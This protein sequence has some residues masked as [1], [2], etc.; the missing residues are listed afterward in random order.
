MAA[1]CKVLFIAMVLFSLEVTTGMYTM[2]IMPLGLMNQIA[3][4][5]IFFIISQRILFDD[6]LKAET[7]K[8]LKVL[9][10]SLFLSHLP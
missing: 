1:L 10:M 5:D 8:A 7:Q 6:V 3:C 4:I 2:I 9:N